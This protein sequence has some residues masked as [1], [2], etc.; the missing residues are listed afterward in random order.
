MAVVV[1][2]ELSILSPE[3]GEENYLHLRTSAH[4]TG[5]KHASKTVGTHAQPLPN[6]PYT[7][8]TIRPVC[9][10]TQNILEPNS[11]LK[12]FPLPNPHPQSAH[13]EVR[14]MYDTLSAPTPSVVTAA[15][16]TTVGEM[17]VLLF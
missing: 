3:R 12:V 16:A 11:Q 5:N 17:R 4:V 14:Q 7:S 6:M 2:S 10:G 9:K 8:H 13:F 15:A 1:L